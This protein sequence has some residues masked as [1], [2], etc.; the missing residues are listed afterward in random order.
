MNSRRIKMLRY[1]VRMIVVRIK[2]RLISRRK[3]AN[4]ARKQGWEDS[5]QFLEQIREFEDEGRAGKL[6][7]K[8][9]TT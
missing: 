2:E 3:A 1:I 4:A 8:G 6:Y 7:D 9:E 5:S